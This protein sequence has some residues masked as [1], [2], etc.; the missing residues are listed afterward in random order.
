M[1]YFN[2]MESHLNKEN[3][4]IYFKLADHYKDKFARHGDTPQG[5]DW[6]NKEDML[7]RYKV[8][9]SLFPYERDS[10]PTVLDFGCGAGGFYKFLE[11]RRDVRYTGIDINSEA[12]DVARM[13]HPGVSFGFLDINSESGW[14]AFNNPIICSESYDYIVCNGTFTVKKDL[15]QRQMTD[16]MCSTLEKLWSKTNK[17]IAFNCMSKI[18]DY[19]RDDL[20]HVSFD[21]LSNWVYDNMSSKFRIRQDYGLREFTMYVFK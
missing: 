3:D 18:L 11:H 5:Y 10:Y 14:S 17:G 21:Q 15:T 8:M 12:I 2:D 1:S 7:T 9:E 6:S 20:Y 4:P 19:E 13:R 16:F